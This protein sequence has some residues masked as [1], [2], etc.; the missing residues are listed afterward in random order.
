MLTRL[1]SQTGRLRSLLLYLVVSKPNCSKA[2]IQQH[3]NNI[4][5]LCSI[6]SMSN[7]WLMSDVYPGSQ[8]VPMDCKEST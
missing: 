7:E 5:R 6:L 1:L 2:Y 8:A 3:A 4:T